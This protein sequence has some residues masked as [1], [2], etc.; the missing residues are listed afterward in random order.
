VATLAGGMPEIIENNI[1]ALL[2]PPGDMAQLSQAI[3]SV[4]QDDELAIHLSL[5]A[6]Q[7]AARLDVEREKNEWLA[8]YEQLLSDRPRDRDRKTIK[9]G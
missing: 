2:V 4:L 9:Q 8:L 5:G 3:Q 7:L 6:Q 1:N